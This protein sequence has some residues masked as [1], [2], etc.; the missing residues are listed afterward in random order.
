MIRGLNLNSFCQYQLI[1]SL[2]CS[3]CVGHND[4]K[5]AQYL[6]DVKKAV[7]HTMTNNLKLHQPYEAV[8]QTRRAIPKMLELILLSRWEKFSIA[9]VLWSS[10]IWQ[11]DV[12]VP[13]VKPSGSGF[14]L[15][16]Y[17]L[18]CLNILFCLFKYT[19]WGATKPW[20]NLTGIQNDW[21]S[22]NYRHITEDESLGPP[23]STV[24]PYKN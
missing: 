15:G 14:I 13:T 17:S 7:F 22:L 18:I 19:L 12:W 21:S 24:L 1:L 3:T 10:A 9:K 23:F 11:I 6:A 20:G 8:Y 4:L 2:A 16:K 5:K